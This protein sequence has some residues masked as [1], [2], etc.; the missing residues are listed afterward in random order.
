MAQTL[1]QAGIPTD[2]V[3]CI[4][5]HDAA[6]RYAVSQCLADDLLIIVSYTEVRT[7]QLVR[8]L[9]SN[10]TN[11]NGGGGAVLCCEE[12]SAQRLGPS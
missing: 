6:L 11:S 2:S 12:P 9:L 8:A 10:E 5:E 1:A 4:S 3:T 7:R